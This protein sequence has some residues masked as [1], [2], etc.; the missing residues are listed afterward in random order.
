M[1]MTT[2]GRAR[3]RRCLGRSLRRTC[4]ARVAAA[5]DAAAVAPLPATTSGCQAADQR[6][7]PA[8]AGPLVPA[9]TQP[10]RVVTGQA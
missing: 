7:A 5:A 6:Q 9:T 8:S 10:T 2:F 4:A 3:L 1:T